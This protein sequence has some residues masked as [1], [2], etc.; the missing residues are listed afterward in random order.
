MVEWKIFALSSALFA[1]LTAL[2]G[3]IG[4][5]N[6]NSNLATFI[7]TVVVLFLLSFLLTIRGEWAN[8]LEIDH[9]SLVFLILSALATGLSWICYYR[10]LQT[11]PVS[12]VVPIDKLSIAF[13]VLL[14]VLFLRE[15]PAIYHWLGI[16]LIICGTLIIVFK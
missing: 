3:K 1:G 2:L 5:Q 7:R 8:P 14:S 16:F 9:K 13:A 4:V 11:G 10:A 6:I 12:L 15:R